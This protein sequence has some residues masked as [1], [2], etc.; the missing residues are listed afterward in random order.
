M[1]STMTTESRPV[2]EMEQIDHCIGDL[3]MEEHR[4]DIVRFASLHGA[5]VAL[6]ILR[7]MVKHR[8]AALEKGIKNYN[9]FKRWCGYVREHER[10][11]LK[12]ARAEKI[13]IGCDRRIQEREQA[14]LKGVDPNDFW[15]R[16][17]QL[18][19]TYEEALR[20]GDDQAKETLQYGRKWLCEEFERRSEQI[21]TDLVR[22]YQ[23]EE[24]SKGDYYARLIHWAN[25][26]GQPALIT[27]A[28]RLGIDI[29]A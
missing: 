23:E 24:M 20:L 8:D 17:D 14:D 7:K 22:Q 29:P 10:V 19:G 12:R 25:V 18:E 27:V 26:F 5:G 6:S 9:V 3:F 1:T 11:D 21:V 28:V 4:R 16:Y 13:Q 15:Q 2:S